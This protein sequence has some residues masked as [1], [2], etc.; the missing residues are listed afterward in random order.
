MRKEKKTKTRR[1]VVAGTGAQVRSPVGLHYR[2]PAEALE[3]A[4]TLA[5][6]LGPPP[7]QMHFEG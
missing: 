7:P 6:A 3:H 2:T 4:K 1:G 5:L